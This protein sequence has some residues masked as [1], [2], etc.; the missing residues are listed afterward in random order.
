M[1][2]LSLNISNLEC[3]FGNI[4]FVVILRF[5]M[6]NVA[7]NLLYFFTF[8]TLILIYKIKNILKFN[9]LIV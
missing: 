5:V 4:M 1:Y 7:L 8:I 9:M 3:C 6:N 2:Y